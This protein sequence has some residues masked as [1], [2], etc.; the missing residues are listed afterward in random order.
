MA[1]MVLLLM[2]NKTVAAMN[3]GVMKSPRLDSERYV[4]QFS[5]IVSGK[6]SPENHLI[7]AHAEKL[8]RIFMAVKRRF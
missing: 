5:A 8:R 1:G 6:E 7:T 2:S 3:R 4:V